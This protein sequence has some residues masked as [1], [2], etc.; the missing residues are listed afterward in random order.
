MVRPPRLLHYDAASRTLVLE[1][2]GTSARPISLKNYAFG[3][4]APAPTAPTARPICDAVG[5]A[6]GA[7]L[8][9]FHDWA[10]ADEAIR[11]VAARNASLHD[12]KFQLSWGGLVSSVDEYPAIL[13]SARAVFKDVTKAIERQVRLRDNPATLAVIHGDFW[14]GK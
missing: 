6:L 5:G 11:V 3:H 2:V 10:G 4:W 1:I 8:R 9:A 14:T 7:W 13:E 12:L